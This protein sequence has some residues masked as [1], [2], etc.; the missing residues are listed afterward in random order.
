MIKN[1]LNLK[2]LALLIAI[3]IWFQITLLQEHQTIINIP[4]RVVNV[5]DNLYLYKQDS[6]KI[7]FRIKGKGIH[8][9]IFHFSNPTIDY[10]GSNLTLGNNLINMETLKESLPYNPNIDFQSKKTEDLI[11]LTTDKIQQKEI[12][13]NLQF[14][15]EQTR[16]NLINENYSINDLFV[17]ISGPALEIN[18]IESINSEEID[19]DLIKSKKKFIRLLPVN[20]HIVIVPPQ[21]ELKQASEIIDTK[22]F[23]FIPIYHNSETYEIFPQ[24]ISIKIQGKRDSLK[25]ISSEDIKA[26]IQDL[27]YSHNDEAT[28]Y[29]KPIPS[30]KIIDYTP[31][32]VSI[33]IL[34]SK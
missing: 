8:L 10:N 5:S 18:K 13:V 19:T 28:V 11:I 6:L 21:I 3:M 7:P 9:L 26:Y 1:N 33:K 29:F 25:S 14:K 27:D 2:I 30:I 22:T 16:T 4:I 32:K 15:S 12:P 17:T 34:K 20:E 23:S 24:R 31:K